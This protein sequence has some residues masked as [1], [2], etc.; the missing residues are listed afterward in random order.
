MQIVPPFTACNHHLDSGAGHPVRRSLWAIVVKV[1]SLIAVI[2]LTLAYG[3]GPLSARELSIPGRD[4]GVPAGDSVPFD[5]P[6]E[7]C[8]SRLP[9]DRVARVYFVLGERSHTVEALSV[10]LVAADIE[11]LMEF[12][13][14]KN[15]QAHRRVA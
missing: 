5:R 4:T 9:V 6:D 13:S 7:R 15:D 3:A 11:K 8:L 10:H 2:V 12:L 14:Q 1:C